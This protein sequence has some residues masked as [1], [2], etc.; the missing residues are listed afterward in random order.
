MSGPKAEVRPDL[1]F[2]GVYDAP[3]LALLLPAL[4]A[5]D[6][7]ELARPNPTHP[8]PVDWTTLGDSVIDHSHF[9]TAPAGKTGRLRRKGARIVDGEGNRVRFWGINLSGNSGTP[10]HEDA[11]LLADIFARWGFNRVRLHG[12]DASWGEI[13]PEGDTTRTLAP[14]ALDRLGYFV[15]T[16]KAR[17]IY[18]NLNLNVAR[19]YRAGDG[20]KDHDTLGYAKGPTFYDPR[21]IELQREYARQLLT[22]RNP[23]T[24]L[25]FAEDPAVC[26]VEVVNENSLLEAWGNGR[27]AER[28]RWGEPGYGGTWGQVPDSY[29][30]DL[31]RLYGEWAD[32][33]LPP[34]E[35]AALRSAAGV[36]N[37]PIPLTTVAEQADGDAARVATD[38][39]FLEH[40]ETRF[41][42]EMRRFL[43]EDLGVKALLVGTSDHNDSLPMYAHT[44]AQV[45]A[46]FDVI[47][48]HGYW[49][50]PEIGGQTVVKND[51][52]VNDPADSTVAQ[53][54][55]TPVEGFPFVISETNHPY[56][57]VWR[58]EGLPVLTAYALLHDWDG[59]DWFDW[60][61][62]DR[63]GPDA[64]AARENG[65]FNLKLDPVKVAQLAVLA[66]IWHR[67]D[68]KPAETTLVRTVGEREAWAM[69]HGGD[70]W[71]R[72]PFFEDGFD[73]RLA[74]VHKTVVRFSD[75]PDGPW[76]A[77]EDGNRVESDTGEIVWSGAKDKRGLVEAEGR[78]TM[79]G[80]GWGKDGF[81]AGAAVALDG[82]P[83]G[84]SEQ[85]IA[86]QA[87][88]SGNRGLTF[89]KDGQTVA[90]WGDG[91]AL[92]AP[93]FDPSAYNIVPIQPMTP[94]G[95]PLEP[96]Y[97]AGW[98][99]AV[100]WRGFTPEFLEQLGNPRED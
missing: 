51:P 3:M 8:Q 87:V 5:A 14:D 55:R 16:L 68:I 71:K 54:A 17:G 36:D 99:G 56:P 94:V 40:L 35:R 97:P 77:L 79:F 26:T 25:T 69:F 30:R 39:R 93:N 60:G 1:G 24:G 100:L 28:P 29:V 10:S 61:P 76:P 42:T 83:R 74:L 84:E 11:D 63:G 22:W 49:Q 59:I 12:F 92:T 95:V 31:H 96:P 46:G 67:Q 19:E 85:I 58:A 23:H 89:E 80:V 78:L 9:L 4:L 32:A 70:L 72:R 48:G 75:E 64:P 7:P 33:T 52:M 91:P 65:W 6:P 82:L 50:H 90:E 38:A 43:R 13:F 21:L 34:D 86:S 45:R 47:H 53:F 18:T 41:F 15:A 62:A 81:S 37:G 73:P 66:P 57:H 44:R 20:V 98:P 2:E 27:F 88:G